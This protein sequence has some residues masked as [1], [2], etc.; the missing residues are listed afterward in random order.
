MKKDAK[1]SWILIKPNFLKLVDKIDSDHKNFYIQIHKIV[2]TFRSKIKSLMTT[3]ILT[4]IEYQT[5]SM[6]WKF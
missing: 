6:N 5:G 2:E 3:S 1:K 4:A